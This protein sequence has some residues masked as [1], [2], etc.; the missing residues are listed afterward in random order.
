MEPVLWILSLG[1][2]AVGLYVWRRSSKLMKELNQL[3][4][5]HYYAESRLK[6]FSEEIRE[7]VQPLRLQVSGLAVG[8]PISPELILSGRLYRDVSAEETLRIIGQNGGQGSNN[9]VVDVR[10]PKEYAVTHMVGATLIPFEELEQRYRNEIPETAEKIFVYCASGERSRL[11][12]DFLSSKG[13]SNLYNI[14]DGMAAWRGPIEG[15]GRIAFIQLQSK[16]EA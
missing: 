16:R 4:R 2:L 3:K 13:Y 1:G 8:K 12:C 6:R 7:A 10:T 5:D 9:M 15:E 11:A 14:Q